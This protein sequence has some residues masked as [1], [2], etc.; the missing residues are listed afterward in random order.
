MESVKYILRK[1]R[2]KAI[3]SL[4]RTRKYIHMRR[5]KVLDYPRT[6]Q[7]PITYA[8]NFDCVMCG[9]HHMAGRKDF[10]AQELRTILSDKLFSRVTG[11]GVNGGEPFLKK[12]LVECIRVMAE[13]LPE[14]RAFSFISNGYFSVR[15]LSKLREIRPICRE[16]GVRLLLALSV[17]GVDD[18][19]DFHRGRSGAW[20]NVNDTIKAILQ[21][22]GSYVDGL[23]V[24][25]TI[26]RHNIERIKEVEAWADTTGLEAA[27]N[28]ATVN[29]RIENEDKVEDFS[30]FSD[31]H[32]RM[33]AQEFFYGQYL[34]TGSEKY[35]A[36]YL[37]LRT[38][39]R[40]APCPCMFNEWI[41]LT[42]DSQIGFCATHSKNLGSALE[43]SAYS[44][45]Q[46]NMPYLQEIREKFCRSCSHY[47]Y[48]LDLEGQ[49][50]M[51]EDQYRNAYMR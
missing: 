5:R 43:N 25:C 44:I 49:K 48:E 31:E 33:L 28:I 9:M 7:L 51:L 30:I 29:V 20:K 19:R 41:T 2:R 32:S 40:Y 22:K 27:Y 35:F 38:G 42:P 39:K 3:N 10:T 8:C 46:E 12:D 14:L 11:I 18:M 6:I 13:T 45:V 23:G 1:A 16:H 47:M 15:I 36:L 21:D 50:L 17:D 24:I 26:T 37:F 34:K 4:K